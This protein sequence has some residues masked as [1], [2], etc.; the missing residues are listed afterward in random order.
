MKPIIAEK[1]VSVITQLCKEIKLWIHPNLRRPNSSFA[2][3]FKFTYFCIV[4]IWTLKWDFAKENEK[5]LTT[6]KTTSKDLNV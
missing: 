6:I 2:Y 4:D 1:I 5:P 3:S